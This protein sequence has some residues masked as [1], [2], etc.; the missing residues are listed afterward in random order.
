MRAALEAALVGAA[1][2]PDPPTHGPRGRQQQ[3]QHGPGV[4]RGKA[5]EEGPAEE[6][7]GRSRTRRPVG[8]AQRGSSDEEEEQQE[9]EEEEGELEGRSGGV[10]AG[11]CPVWLDVLVAL[12]P[13]SVLVEPLGGMLLTQ[14]AMRAWDGACRGWAGRVCVGG[15]WGRCAQG[16]SG[17][18]LYCDAGLGYGV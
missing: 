12:L 8:Y 2:A 3:R 13:L 5:R 10:D 16:F 15:G 14:A 11:V 4:G 6:R 17:A 7:R 1:T 9:E 18:R